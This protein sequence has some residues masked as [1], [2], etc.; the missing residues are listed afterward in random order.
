L[1]AG[2]ALLGA[3][4]EAGEVRGLEA[5]SWPRL[6]GL[7]AVLLATVFTARA[8]ERR[9][10]GTFSIELVLGWCWVPPVGS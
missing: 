9:R 1:I 5:I 2:L 4:A 3:S 7:T 6:I 10:P 8:I